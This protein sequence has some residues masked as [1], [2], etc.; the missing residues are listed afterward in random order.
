MCTFLQKQARPEEQQG[1]NGR[2]DKKEGDVQGRTSVE[3]GHLKFRRA[4][5]Q[6]FGATLHWCSVATNKQSE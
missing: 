1:G 2:E 4:S 5:G 3:T 6:G